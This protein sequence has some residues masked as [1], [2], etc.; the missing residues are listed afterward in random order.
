MNRKKVLLLG[1]TGK[2]GVALAAALR[3]GY[4]LV[5]ANRPE[6]DATDF[7]KVA[8]IIRQVHP[9]VVINTIAHLGIEPCEDDPHKAFELNALYP[10]LLAQLS[11]ENDFLL[12]HFSTDA[13]FADRDASYAEDDVPR[14]VNVYGMTKYAGD[15]FVEA[16]APKYYIARISVLFG[17]TNKH[18]QFVEKMLDKLQSHDRL[19]PNSPVLRIAGD[20][21]CS[22]CYSRDV[23]EAVRTL[24]QEEYP[25]GLYHLANEGKA[26]LYDLMKEIVAT[27]GV[28]AVVEKVSYK[29]FPARGRKNTSTPITTKKFKPLRPWRQAVSEYCHG[30]K[31]VAEQT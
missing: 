30:L 29:D 20:I 7:A 28:D 15:M 31:H 3:S 19:S 18:T 16:F 12:V 8:Q 23:A 25:Y 5:C 1:S 11:A 2:M 4:E 26:S 27:L 13:V 9:D 21:I 17:E 10:R 14:P 22:P 6:F 24:L